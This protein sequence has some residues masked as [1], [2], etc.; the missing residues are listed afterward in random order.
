MRIRNADFEL[1]KDVYEYLATFS[2]TRENLLEDMEAL[3]DSLFN[4]QDK[5]RQRNRA[6]AAK[7]RENG[8]AWNSSYHPKK[9]KYIEE[10]E[11]NDA[12]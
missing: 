4:Q 5:E 2:T 9:S 6:R 3:I 10:A 7:N 11:S 1:L 12:D 8:Y